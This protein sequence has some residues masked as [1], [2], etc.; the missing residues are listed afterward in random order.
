MAKK[1]MSG[2][3]YLAAVLGRPEGELL[4]VL[5]KDAQQASPDRG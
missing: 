3:S 2:V 4:N 5:G 1:L